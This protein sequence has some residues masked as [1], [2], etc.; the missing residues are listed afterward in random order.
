MRSPEFEA[1]R[2]T[3]VAFIG[4]DHAKSTGRVRQNLMKKG[5]SRELADEVIAYLEAIDYVDDRRAARRVARRYRGRRLRSRRAMVDVF[6]RNGI[7]RDTAWAAAEQLAS[8]ETTA[9][10]LLD[11]TYDVVTEANRTDALKLLSRRGYALYVAMDAV[12]DALTTN[13][14]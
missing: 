12:R 2:E 4:I 5:V 6:L 7:A 14:E 1:A 9:R 13:D 11:A 3:A 8:D 10:Q